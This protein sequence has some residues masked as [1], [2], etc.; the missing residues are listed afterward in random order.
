MPFRFLKYHIL[1]SISTPSVCLHVSLSEHCPVYIGN[2]VRYICLKVFNN[3]CLGFFYHIVTLTGTRPLIVIPVS[4]L[5]K[6][7]LHVNHMRANLNSRLQKLELIQNRMEPILL[8]WQNCTILSRFL[9]IYSQTEKRRDWY[10]ICPFKLRTF[11]HWFM[12]ILLTW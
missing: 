8:R 10:Y 5:S 7:L 9:L 3:T 1:L 11:S 6:L 2:L 12:S 4:I